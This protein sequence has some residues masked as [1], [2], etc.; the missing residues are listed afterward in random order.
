MVILAR[1]EL[2]VAARDGE[3]LLLT[4]GLPVLLLVFFSVVDVLPTGSTDPIDFLVPGIVTLAL[5]STGFVR[6]AIGLGFDRSFGALDRYAVSPV[7]VIDFL[8]SRALAASMIVAIQLVVL[9]GLGVALGWRPELH[10]AVAGVVSLASVGFFAL[11]LFVGS[12]TEGLRALA[13]ANTLYVVLLLFSGIVFDLSELPDGLSALT[14]LLPTTAT[15]E[16]LRAT[17]TGSAGEGRYWV[18]LAAWA[19]AGPALAV[20]FFRWR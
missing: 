6:L 20:R 9:L 10:P 11:G 13:V 4:A 16:L 18:V 5:L 14:R 2:R 19:L 7:G 17:T 3:Q 8:G 15:A 12:V 1:T